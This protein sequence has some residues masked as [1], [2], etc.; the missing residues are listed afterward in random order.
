MR[1]IKLHNRQITQNQK[2]FI[3]AILVF[4]FIVLPV[5]SLFTPH[6]HASPYVE[7]MTVRIGLYYGD[8][9]LSS[10]TIAAGSINVG[11]TSTSF[12]ASQLPIE[13]GYSEGTTFTELGKTNSSAVT[14]SGVSAFSAIGTTVSEYNANNPGKTFA[15][16]FTPGAMRINGSRFFTGYFE[17]RTTSANKLEIINVLPMEDYLKG[18]IPY[19]MSSSYHPE[20][21][22]AQAVAS[23]SWTYRNLSKHSKSGFNMCSTTCCQAYLGCERRTTKTDGLVDETKG[24]VMA[25]GG[26]IAEGLYFSSSGGSTVSSRSFWGSSYVPY[27]TAVRVPE[28][29]GYM[30]WS[31]NVTLDKLYSLLK[32]RAEFASLSGGLRSFDISAIENNSD[33]VIGL[34]ATDVNGKTVTING[35]MNVYSII[36][37][38]GRSLNKN[39]TSTNFTFKHAYSMNI[40]EQGDVSYSGSVVVATADGTETYTGM[41]SDLKVATASGVESSGMTTNSITV[42]G[43]GWGHGVGMSQ[44]GAKTMA[45]DGYTFDQILK[46]FYTGVTIQKVSDF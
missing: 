21:L 19:E 9:A 40:V 36:A 22:K 29:R 25:S 5:S 38:V 31:F 15:L 42:V 8:G 4:A 17:I 34:K 30:N 10:V 13:V 2:R 11:A 37:Y 1:L 43:K 44:A 6:V 32:T 20:A 46:R 26:I 12:A 3:V 33:H 28:E 14:F 45:E 35:G 41:P 18:V 27:L 7:N 39:Y 23:R 16:R 24:I